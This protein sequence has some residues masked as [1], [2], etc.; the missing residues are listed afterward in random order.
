MCRQPGPQEEGLWGHVLLTPLQ[1]ARGC[2]ERPRR[3]QPGARAG[4]ALS[5]LCCRGA[6]LR[7]AAARAGHRELASWEPLSQRGRRWRV[8]ASATPFS[9]ATAL[10][11]LV[12]QSSGHLWLSPALQRTWPSAFLVS[13]STVTPASSAG[14]CPL[15]AP[16][17][18][19][20]SACAGGGHPHRDR[21]YRLRGEHAWVLITALAPVRQR[22]V[23]QEE[24]RPRRKREFSAHTRTATSKRVLSKK[25]PQRLLFFL[26]VLL[27]SVGWEVTSSFHIPAL[28][29]PG[30]SFSAPLA[31]TR[32][33]ALSA[34]CAVGDP[35]ASH[36][37]LE[38]S[39]IDFRQSHVLPVSFHLNQL[40]PQYCC[41]TPALK[42]SSSRK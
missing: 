40:S 36:P 7:A 21:S 23:Y 17:S 16:E 41:V 33:M 1:Q 13:P 10:R 19:L 2:P 12:G 20:R 18:C 35:P 42:L 11:F 6:Q 38:V 29:L 37:E 39:L 5:L 26:S 31:C 22:Q 8:S 34:V 15:P 14:P 9:G 4:A 30:S 32:A 24:G 3:S 27:S 28:A 25:S